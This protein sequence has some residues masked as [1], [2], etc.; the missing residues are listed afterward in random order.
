MEVQT[1][2]RGFSVLLR[3]Y[4]AKFINSM[5]TDRATVS[6]TLNTSKVEARNA[7]NATL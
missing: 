1:C 7:V 2:A 4:A 6:V 3:E 5:D